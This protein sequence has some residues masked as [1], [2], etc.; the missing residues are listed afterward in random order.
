MLSSPSTRQTDSDIVVRTV[1]RHRTC[2][3]NDD[4]AVSTMR[5][6]RVV[7]VHIPELCDVICSIGIGTAAVDSMGYWSP[8]Q[9]RYPIYYTCDS[10]C[11]SNH[12]C[13]RSTRKMTILDWDHNAAVSP[14][15]AYDSYEILMH[16]TVVAATAAADIAG[17]ITYFNV[18][19]HQ[20]PAFPAINTT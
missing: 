19:S 4:D 2:H 7:I 13:N 18:Y 6:Q 12:N 15:L 9:Y 16:V 3:S 17:I 14:K 1:W 5:Q 11:T 20:F 8:A 10:T